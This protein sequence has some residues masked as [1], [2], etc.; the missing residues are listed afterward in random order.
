[1]IMQSLIKA[2][3]IIWPKHESNTPTE[4]IRFQKHQHTRETRDMIRGNY[5][6][7]SD[8]MM[9]CYHDRF[10]CCKINQS[11]LKYI[12]HIVFPRIIR[13]S[14]GLQMPSPT[15]NALSHPT[16]WA[17]V[18]SCET[19]CVVIKISKDNIKIYGNKNVFVHISNNGLQRDVFVAAWFH[20]SICKHIQCMWSTAW[21]ITRMNRSGKK[22]STENQ[23][24]SWCQLCCHW[25][26]RYWRHYL[27]PHLLTWFNLNPSVGK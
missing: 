23:T 20:S 18:F 24:L 21:R 19:C 16:H 10:A 9:V 26:T 17:F 12:L 1:M 11:S 8:H 27:G 6:L 2:M 22:R 5:S 15:G 25:R 7:N 3:S 14:K 13:M 4:A